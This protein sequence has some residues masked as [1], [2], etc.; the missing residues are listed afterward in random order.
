M[1]RSLKDMEGCTVQAEDGVMG[2]VVNLLLEEDRWVTRFLV[3]LT[4][5]Y[6]HG[7]KVLVSPSALH[8]GDGATHRFHL[9]STLDQIR[10]HPGDAP[11]KR[12][13]RPP[14]FRGS[15]PG[16][17]P[18]RR[19]SE[20][21]LRSAQ[22]IRGFQV[23]GKEDSVGHVEDFILDDKTWEIRY[24]VVDTRNWWSG[25]M[26]LVSPQWA[27]GINWE[28]STLYFSLDRAQIRTCPEWDPATGISRAYEERLH[29]HYRRP[30]Y[31]LSGDSMAE[32]RTTAAV[33]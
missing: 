10:T 3:V 15:A 6:L 5:A 25:K 1:L 2:K 19:D 18:E 33:S 17:D 4:G 8:E 14:A 32:H 13:S 23:R 9:A 26:V 29:H 16:E 30:A 27:S 21:P 20:L 31:W 22:V 28:A 24:L 7:R 11:D 12:L